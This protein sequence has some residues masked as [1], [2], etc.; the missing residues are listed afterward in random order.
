MRKLLVCLFFLTA[1]T[2]MA[3][4]L[5]LND[6]EY[7]ERQGVNVL[8]FSNSFNG[9]FNDEKNSGIEIIHHGVRT[10]QGGAV[11]LNNTPEQWDLVPKMTSRKV[12]KKNQSIEVG[13]RYD[14]YHFDG[15]MIAQ[16]GWYVLRSVLPAN[17]TGK[18]LS[19][20]VEPH[21]IPSWIREPNIGFSQVGY[22]P[23]QPKVSVIELDKND[24][25]KSTATL[26]RIKEDG[27]TEKAYEGAVT[28]WGTYYKYNYV[29]FDFSSIKQPGVYYIQY[30][31][32]KTNALKA[33][34]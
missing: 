33:G 2:V 6:L 13:L 28:T 22:I 16:N 19:W 20:T 11:R 7:F 9:G 3:Q 14:D 15:R 17:K 30:G 24:P 5:H 31:D 29:K 12:D 4:D 1:T 25:V 26:W 18:V 10:V 34:R 27:T 23:E 21:A 32:T 8:V